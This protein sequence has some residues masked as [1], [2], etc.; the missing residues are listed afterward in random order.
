MRNALAYL[1]AFGIIWLRTSVPHVLEK[2]TSDPI[3]S[4]FS[5]GGRAL[6]AQWAGARAILSFDGELK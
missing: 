1:R 2:N 5:K 3:L 4:E 6:A